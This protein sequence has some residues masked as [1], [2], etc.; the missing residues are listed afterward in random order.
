M[1]GFR[2]AC[3]A[4]EERDVT[5]GHD[6][7]SDAQEHV[8]QLRLVHARLA[9]E[10][11]EQLGELEP[12]DHPLGGDIRERGQA[13]AHVAQHLD[14]DAA[15]AEHHG[16]AEA[17]GADRPDG[18]LGPAGDELL[19]LERVDLGDRLRHAV[20]RGAQRLLVAEVD[21]HRT[22]FGLVDQLGGVGLED[23][24]IAELGGCG[25]DE[26]GGGTPGLARWTA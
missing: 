3:D 24:G 25:G 7:A 22:G 11:P 8:L 12:P 21:G 18:D 23:D 26:V 16:G 5:G 14:E 6:E 10:R 1:V 20:Q 2:L 13:E 9:A 19:D 17:F 4:P 15:Q